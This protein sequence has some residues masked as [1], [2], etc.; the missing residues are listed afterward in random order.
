MPLGILLKKW[1]DIKLMLLND[2]YIVVT[3][4][5]WD[6]IEE[7]RWYQTEALKWRL[8][9]GYKGTLCK[10]ADRLVGISGTNID[11]SASSDNHQYNG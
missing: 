1:G 2:D 11:A 9:C 6:L 7:M 8:H 10:N 4:A 3:K 5:T